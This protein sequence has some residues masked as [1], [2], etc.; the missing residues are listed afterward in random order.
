MTKKE[1]PKHLGRG[2]EALIGSV[3]LS[4]P[5]PD[6]PQTADFSTKERLSQ[7]MRQ[8]PLNAIEP[9]PYQPRTTWN[10]TELVELADSIRANGVIQPIVVRKAGDGYQLIAGERRLRASEL[11]GLKDIP[12]VIRE[13][14]DEQLLEL[15]LVENIHRSNLNPLERARAYQKYLSTFSLSQTEAAERLGENRSVVANYLRLLDLP[16]EVRQ[17]LIDEQLSMGHARALLA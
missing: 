8:I 6:E 5:T 2:L 15:A 16:Q 7:S 17:M 13:A 14:T 11:A 10:E 3:T 4:M 12:A 9:N 1:R